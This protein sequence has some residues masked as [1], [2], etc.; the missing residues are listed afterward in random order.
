M[1]E[2]HE[3]TRINSL[4][5]KNNIHGEMRKIFKKAI[6]DYACKYY[7]LQKLIKLHGRTKSN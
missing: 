3:Y 7:Q 5:N 1:E 2:T 4:L 6:N